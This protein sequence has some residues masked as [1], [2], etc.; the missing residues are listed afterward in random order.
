MSEF[1]RYYL[2]GAEVETPIRFDAT[3]L[4]FDETITSP[5]AEVD[6]KN[7]RVHDIS[8]VLA[9]HTLG[10]K[11][12]NDFLRTLTPEMS[13]LSYAKAATPTLEG[14]LAWLLARAEILPRH[15]KYNSAHPQLQ[16]F[17]KLRMTLHERVL[18]DNVKL[19]PGFKEF[20]EWADGELPYG[21]GMATM[22]INPFV[23]IIIDKFDLESILPKH[24]RATLDTKVGIIPMKPKP[25]RM[26]YD[27][28][29]ERLHTPVDTPEQRARVMGVDDSWGGVESS[30]DAGLHT[31]GFASN[32]TR[33]GFT[34]EPV[35]HVVED[36][37]ELL[38][39]TK[40][41]NKK[42]A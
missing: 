16:D 29:F 23:K 37:Y 40:E 24:R 36:F 4:D 19:S 9:A 20:A 5:F 15:V 8:R 28:A 42:A 2:P 33:E 31:I 32:H 41:V 21:L 17:I 3:I 34:G 13:A 38:D 39:Y 11:W 12:K 25:D 30:S 1:A 7:V 27:T 18:K 14:S 22:E 35:H 10:D 6:G 26:I